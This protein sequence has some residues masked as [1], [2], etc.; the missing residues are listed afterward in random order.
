MAPQVW[1]RGHSPPQRRSRSSVAPSPPVAWAQHVAGHAACRPAGSQSGRGADSSIVVP[2]SLTRN[3]IPRR[4]ARSSSSC[5]RSGGK[6]CIA[7]R[8]TCSPVR[9][10]LD[11]RAQG[12][13]HVVAQDDRRRW[14]G[15][16]W[17]VSVSQPG[18]PDRDQ[19][20]PVAPVE[21]D[22]DAGRPQAEIAA[23]GIVDE[24]GTGRSPGRPAFGG[25]CL[26]SRRSI[27]SPARRPRSVAVRRSVGTSPRSSRTMGR[28]SK[29]N[30]LVASRACWT[31]VAQRLQLLRRA[32]VAHDSPGAA[33]S[34]TA[35]RCWPGSVL[36]RRACGVR[37]PAAAPPAPG[38]W[39]CDREH[40]GSRLPGARPSRPR[41]GR[42]CRHSCR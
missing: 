6:E 20:L 4:R 7:T 42:G 18:C 5:S 9:V 8:A 31:I 25:R 41:T 19:Q 40:P 1:E 3:P 27:S 21:A 36:G 11:H 22:H 29:M 15:G 12:R 30:S 13:R 10:L 2:S 24:S 28:T 26:A 37:S 14:L 34:P 35:A 32:R 17:L 16:P 33:R 23:D 38:A 39:R